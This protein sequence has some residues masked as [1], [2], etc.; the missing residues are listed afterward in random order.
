[1]SVVKI[2]VDSTCDLSPELIHKHDITVN[3]LYTILGDKSYADGVDIKPDGIYKFV[4]ENNILPKTSAASVEDYL[5]LFKTYVEKGME[6]I[7]F[8]ISSDMS[9]SHQNA[10]ISAKEVGNVYVIDTLNLSTGSGLLVLDAADYR[11]QG[12]GAAEIAERVRTHVPLVRASFVIDNLEYLRMGGRC[13]AVAMLGANLLK[14][15]PRI[16][17]TDGKMG[18]GGKY[19]GAYDKVLLKYTEDMLSC[20]DV[21]TRR[22]FITHTKCDKELVNQVRE[23]VCSLIPFEEVYETTAGCVITSHCGPN[24]LGVLFETKKQ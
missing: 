13:S 21:N 12:M 24:T 22:V 20:P 9:S 2:T 1:M 11:A 16:E 6:V 7:H 8:N 23:K 3:P 10:L 18:M 14:I 4:A 5:S 17:V 19:R 15:K